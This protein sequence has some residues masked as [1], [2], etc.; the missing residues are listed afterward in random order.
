[1][2]VHFVG[3]GPGDPELIT[4]RGK[5]LIEQAD[6]IVYAGSLVNDELLRNATGEKINSYGLTLE[7][8]TELMINAAKEGRS[9]VRLHSGD[10]ALYSAIAEQIYALKLHNVDY[11]I[12]PGVSSVFAAAAAVGQQLTSDTL[13]ITRPAGKTLSHDKLTEFSKLRPTMAIFLG[14]DKIDDVMGR[15]RYDA[16]TPVSVV[17]HASWDDQVIVRGTVADICTKSREAGI[18]RSAIILIGDEYALESGRRS[19]LYS[20]KS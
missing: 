11:E 4:V 7:Q 10:P 16:A 12:V 20:P 18:S 9:V 19:Y 6:L 15:V 5:R 13:V 14:A 17:Y 3:A 1:M 2:K 8:I